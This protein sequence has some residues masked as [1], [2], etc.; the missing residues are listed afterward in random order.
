MALLTRQ[1]EQIGADEQGRGDRK[2]AEH[3]HEDLVEVLLLV[4]HLWKM[5]SGHLTVTNTLKYGHVYM[6]RMAQGFAFN[7][8]YFLT[9]P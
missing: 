9:K 8:F 5:R 6:E 7:F 1:P 2:H 4:G 3:D